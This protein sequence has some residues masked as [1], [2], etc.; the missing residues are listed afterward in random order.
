MKTNNLAVGLLVGLSIGGIVGVLFAP[1][2]GL[3]LEKN[4]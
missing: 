1:K 3:K 4:I 2:N